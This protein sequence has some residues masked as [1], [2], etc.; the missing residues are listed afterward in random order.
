MTHF[1]WTCPFCNRGATITEKNHY[2]QANHFLHGN[3]DGHLVIVV[4]ATTCPNAE[5]KE[6]EL[7]ARL[8]KWDGTHGRAVGE[9][10]TQ[11]QL[12]PSSN[13]KV[14]PEYIPKPVLDDYTEA[15][16]IRDLS[17]KASATLARRCLQGIIRD[18]WGI[19]KNRLV[20]EISELKPLIDSATWGAIDAVR[21]IGNIGAHMEKD[22][23]LVIDVEPEEAQLLIGLIEIL[24]KDWYIA[25]HERQVHLNGIV[26]LAG[27]KKAAASPEG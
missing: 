17:P 11:W 19:S 24:L 23:N 3:K 4:S 16:A 18:Y 7:K 22:I 6:Y 8:F 2:S 25:R 12:R 5:C 13:A 10:L 9:P 15:C 1:L 27:A 21:S 14:F 20:E 26:A